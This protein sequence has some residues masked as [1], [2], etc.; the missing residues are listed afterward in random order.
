MWIFFNWNGRVHA[1]ASNDFDQF[2]M[3]FITFRC[4][5]QWLSIYVYELLF[6]SSVQNSLAQNQQ[7]SCRMAVEKKISISELACQMCNDFELIVIAY[8][9]SLICYHWAHVD[10]N[11]ILKQS[12]SKQK[13]N[14]RT[15][16][17]NS[18]IAR[19][20]HKLNYIHHSNCRSSAH[21]E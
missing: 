1:Y 5:F 12:K 17:E 11:S 7:Q 14:I 18:G 3:E 6:K 8:N 20:W 13:S 16:D 19:N 2:E 21:V 10:R 9:L 4:W 15:V